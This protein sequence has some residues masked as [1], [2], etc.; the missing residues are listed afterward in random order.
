VVIG[1]RKVE[2]IVDALG[3]EPITIDLVDVVKD[4]NDEW[5]TYHIIFVVKIEQ[6]GR[7]G[8]FRFSD[9]IRSRVENESDVDDVK[10]FHALQ[11]ALNGASLYDTMSFDEYNEMFNMF[12]TV[13][14]ER[15]YAFHGE[16]YVKLHVIFNVDG[17]TMKRA[18]D[19]L[20]ER[21]DWFPAFKGTYTFSRDFL[22]T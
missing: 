10:L 9:D 5:N 14:N 6:N 2:I 7:S 13:N 12:G 4:W 21:Y 22:G 8:I 19:E 17:E 15:S 3:N 16:E 11:D 18:S 1:L 20:L